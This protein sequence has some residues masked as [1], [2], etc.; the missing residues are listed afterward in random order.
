MIDI[1][2]HTNR[3][4]ETGISH[5]GTKKIE[6]YRD[7]HMRKGEIEARQVMKTALE[8]IY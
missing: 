4:D 5:A 1:A 3:K 6:I 7:S 2:T 8:D